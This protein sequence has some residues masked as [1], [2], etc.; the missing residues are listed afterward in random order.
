MRD[1]G[2]NSTTMRVSGRRRMSPCSS[3]L[4]GQSPP[5][6]FKC[7]PASIICGSRIVALRLS[8][9]AVVTMSTPCTASAVERQRAT[10]NA[11]SWSRARL[12]SSFSVAAMSVSNR[13][14]SRM[15]SR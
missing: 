15:P 3:V 1:C 8:A 14:S 6:A 10:R 13:R 4:P 7:M 11:G 12:R 2:S 5:I 9:V